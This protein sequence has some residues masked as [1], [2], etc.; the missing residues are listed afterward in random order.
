[1]LLKTFPDASYENTWDALFTVGDLFRRI[2]VPIAERF[3]FEY[4]FDDD[5]RVTAHLQYIRALPQ[6]AKELYP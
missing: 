6:D 3:G 1:M 5:R 2:A 4:P